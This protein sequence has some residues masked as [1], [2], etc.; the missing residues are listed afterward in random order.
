MDFKVGSCCMCECD[1]VFLWH[2]LDELQ[3]LMNVLA[4]LFCYSHVYSIVQTKNR[5]DNID[6]G[7]YC[8]Y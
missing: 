4:C 3:K 8:H 1:V 2:P 7:G 5:N 6:A